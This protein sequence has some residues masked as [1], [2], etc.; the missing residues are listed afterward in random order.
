MVELH[1]DAGHRDFGI[2]GSRGKGAERTLVL[3]ALSIEHNDELRNAEHTTHDYAQWLIT[4]LRS[5]QQR[6]AG[7]RSANGYTVNFPG[8]KSHVLESFRNLT[9]LFHERLVGIT[10]QQFPESSVSP[11]P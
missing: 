6:G 2:S 3:A 1:L 4:P 11:S 10:E 5:N 7:W 9:E 8:L